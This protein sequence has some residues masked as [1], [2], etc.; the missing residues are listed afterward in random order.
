L[1]FWSRNGHELFYRT[2]DQRIMIASYTVKGD[3]FIPQRPR[4]WYSKRIANVGGAGTSTSLPMEA[5]RRVDAGGSRRGTRKPESRNAGD[6][7]CRRSP[8]TNGGASEIS[9]QF[10]ILF[11]HCPPFAGTEQVRG[12]EV[13]HRADLF[14]LGCVLF[15][16]VT[17]A[18]AF[19][20]ESAADTMSAV[21]TKDPLEHAPA[22]GR[23]R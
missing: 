22:A 15:E 21:L 18:R 3:S 16:M 13:D 10:A 23:C 14:S 1:P 11:M 6:E 20:G 8:S 4:L 19:H 5:L 9:R 12:K 7:L 2:E 17:G